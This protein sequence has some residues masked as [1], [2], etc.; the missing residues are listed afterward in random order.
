MAKP[1]EA[2]TSIPLL[3]NGEPKTC[4]LRTSLPH[5][6]VE[7]GMNPQLVVVEYNGEILHRQLWDQTLLQSGDRLEIITIVGGG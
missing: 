3:V 1:S 5:F 4:T 2:P 7:L 6:L